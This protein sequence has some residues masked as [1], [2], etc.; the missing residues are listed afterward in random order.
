MTRVVEVSPERLDGWLERFAANNPDDAGE[1]VPQRIVAREDFPHDPLAVL[2]VRRGGYA[3]GLARAGAFSAAHR[4]S[5][6]VRFLKVAIPLLAM[7]GGA[8]FVFFAF[9]DPFSIRTV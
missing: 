3:V 8:L 5:R 4:H 6:R 7:C 9:F 2:L 1:P